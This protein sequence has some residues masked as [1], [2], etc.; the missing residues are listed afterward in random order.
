MRASVSHLLF[1]ATN[2]SGLWPTV[3]TVDSGHRRALHQWGPLGAEKRKRKEEETMDKIRGSSPFLLL[4]TSGSGSGWLWQ[5]L[6]ITPAVCMLGYEPLAD[7]KGGNSNLDKKL[8][9]MRVALST[10]GGQ[11]DKERTARWASW[12]GKLVEKSLECRQK[13]VS[14]RREG[15]TRRGHRPASLA[16]SNTALAMTLPCGVHR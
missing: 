10:P 2:P 12:R 1:N 15:S 3:S 11:G 7:C 9:W 6:A 16:R 13:E 5:R 4:F 8:G 14:R